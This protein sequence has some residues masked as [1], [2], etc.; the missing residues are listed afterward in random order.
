MN[1]RYLTV[2][3]IALMFRVSKMTVYRLI[4]RR[5]LRAVRIG[6]T[7]RIAESAVQEYIA[8]TAGR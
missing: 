1:D 3:E 8:E 6:R 5:E 2:Q 4:E 7:F